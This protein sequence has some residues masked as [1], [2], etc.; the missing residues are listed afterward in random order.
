MKNAGLSI[1][2][3]QTCNCGSL[4]TLVTDTDA[5]P[6]RGGYINSVV[7]YFEGTPRLFLI[8]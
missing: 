5:I 6:F 2:E 4:P 3:H 8:G 1:A 7:T